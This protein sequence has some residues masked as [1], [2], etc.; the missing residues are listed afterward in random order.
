MIIT[1]V[2]TKPD[3]Q[4]RD[5]KNEHFVVNIVEQIGFFNEIKKRSKQKNL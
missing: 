4:K 2:H 5:R 1:F 3:N